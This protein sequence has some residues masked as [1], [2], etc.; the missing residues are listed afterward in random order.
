MGSWNMAA[1]ALNALMTIQEQPGNWKFR[2]AGM[3]NYF[4]PARAANAWSRFPEAGRRRGV[5]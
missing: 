3:T 4:D 5:V 2:W 1:P